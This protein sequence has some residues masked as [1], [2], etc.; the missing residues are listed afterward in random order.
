VS[1]LAL[2]YTVDVAV[3]LRRPPRVGRW[4][5]FRLAAPDG[6]TAELVA[7]QWAESTPGVVMAVESV[8]VDWEEAR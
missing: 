6:L 8:V 5:R 4:R 3:A 7:C 2:V 1:D